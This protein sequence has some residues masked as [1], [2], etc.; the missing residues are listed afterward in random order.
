MTGKA[1][2]FVW[3][4]LMTSDVDAAAAFYGEVVRWSAKDSFTFDEKYRFWSMGDTYI[5][6]LMGISLEAASNGM[7]PAWLG[8]LDVDDVDVKVSA[9]TEA[10]G[11]VH[12]PPTDIES[13]GR[14][15]MMTDPQGAA[16]YIMKP[17]GTEPSKAFAHGEVGHIGWNELHTTD[18]E[19]A[20]AFYSAEFGWE[21]KHAMDMGSMGTYQMFG[22]GAD[23]MGGMMNNPHIPHAAWLFY[24]NVDDIDAAE[25][26]LA[27]AG[28][29][30]TRGP[31]E[32][33]GNMWIIEGCDPQGAAFALVGPRH[34]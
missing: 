19:A 12:M 33:P 1:S 8:Y 15:A 29:A 11:R 20:L 16:F 27:S 25:K 26:R 9:I 32:V 4:E 14:L 10:G 24:F 5:G 28:G 30:L 22:A 23:A 2:N 21:K 6:G 3:Y 31:Q 17:K 13:V 18:W 34:A 7:R